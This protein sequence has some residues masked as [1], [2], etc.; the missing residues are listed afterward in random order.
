MNR[1]PNRSIGLSAIMRFR[2]SIFTKLIPLVL[3]FSFLTACG[4]DSSQSV[5]IEA[6]TSVSQHEEPLFWDFIQAVLEIFGWGL[7][8]DSVEEREDSVESLDKSHFSHLGRRVIEAL[9]ETYPDERYSLWNFSSDSSFENGWVID[10]PRV[11][12]KSVEELTLAATCERNDEGC[13]PDFGLYQCETQSDCSL[14]G[15]CEELASTSKGPDSPA[16]KLCV[17]HSDWLMDEFY[18]TIIEAEE[19]VDIS[20][21]TEASGRFVPMLRNAITVLS[22]KN[23]PITVRFLFGD[24]PGVQVAM[25]Q[26]AQNLTRDVGFF[27]DLKLFV[28]NYR[29]RF[30]SWNHA[31]I[32][33]IDGELLVTGG[34]NFWADHYLS[35][36]PV[37]DL[38]MRLRGTPADDAHHFLNRLWDQTCEDNP[39]FINSSRA[40]APFSFSDCPPPFSSPIQAG[41]TNGQRVISV[42]RMG[43]LGANPADVAIVELMNSAQSN[44][45]LSIQDLGPVQVG[46]ITVTDWP[47][48]VLGA[49]AKAIVRGVEIDIIFSNKGSTPGGLWV[50]SASYSNGWEPVD[51]VD[52]LKEWVRNHPEVIPDAAA[53]ETLLCDRFH[54]GVLRTST[55]DE[56]ASGATQANH[57]KFIVADDEAFYLGSQNL[58]VAHLAEHGVVVDDGAATSEILAAYWEPLWN[59]SERTVVSEKGAQGCQF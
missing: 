59:E 20:T 18:N 56:W 2:A 36:A 15:R 26:L 54:P 50:G 45:K 40:V 4:D 49:L 52:R 7:K 21:L 11:F 24:L 55:E 12:G 37:H 51:A 14:G 34:H 5:E 1:I 48:E 44:L 39:A 35:T 13:D 32:V 43:R 58:Y 31:K 46:N 25:N 17:G 41:T 29:K 53:F 47:E 57:A 19:Y 38:S 28:G 10:S 8:P 42:G 33:A 6:K 27:S 30:D 3:V 9:E 16:Y 22:K 23:N